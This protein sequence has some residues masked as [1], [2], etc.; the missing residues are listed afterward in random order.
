MWWLCYRNSATT[1][2]SH[3][4]HHY[5]DVLNEIVERLNQQMHTVSI[6]LVNQMPC[7]QVVIVP[8]ASAR[9]SLG[10]G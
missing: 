1:Y 10:H 5:V 9:L 4:T 2:P 6:I 7:E 8:T 3:R